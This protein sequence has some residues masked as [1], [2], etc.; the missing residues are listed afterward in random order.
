MATP[1]IHAAAKDGKSDIVLKRLENGADAGATDLS[2]NTPLHLA[3]AHGHVQT[4]EVLLKHGADV[5]ALDRH[6]NTPLHLAAKAGHVEAIT[7]LLDSGANADARNQS[8]RTPFMLAVIHEAPSEKHVDAAEALFCAGADTKLC[9]D[10]FA[11]DV[12]IKEFMQLYRQTVL[13][14][15]EQRDEIDKRHKKLV[16]DRLRK[17]EKLSDVTVDFCVGNVIAVTS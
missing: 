8:E 6:G 12:R 1:S 7:L 2:G 5:N 10:D 15:I 3:V 13:G 11:D 4:M 14:R 9:R 16:D 17:L